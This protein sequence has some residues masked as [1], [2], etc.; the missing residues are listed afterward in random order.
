[1]Q[2]SGTRLAFLRQAFGRPADGYGV[3][4]RRQLPSLPVV[5]PVPDSD[6][7]NPYANT[8]DI[9]SGGVRSNRRSQPRT[10]VQG[11]VAQGGGGFNKYA[12]GAKGLGVTPNVGP[13]QD[14]SGYEERDRNAAVSRNALLRRLQARGAGRFMTPENLRENYSG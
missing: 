6:N 3:G 10:P 5:E 9:L 4:P 8:G 14:R 2:P 12:A 7:Y 1:M 11:P 13:I